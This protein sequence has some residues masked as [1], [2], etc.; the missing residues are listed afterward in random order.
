MPGV[1]GPRQ[2]RPSPPAIA[3][4]DVSGCQEIGRGGKNSAPSAWCFETRPEPVLGPRKARTR[5]ALLSM[6]EAIDSIKGIPRPEV[7]RAPRNG[8]K[9]R[10]SG[11]RPRPS[12]RRRRPRL[13]Q[14][15]HG[16]DPAAR[17]LDYSLPPAYGRPARHETLPCHCEAPSG[18]AAISTPQRLGGRDC[19]VAPLLAMTVQVGGRHSWL[20]FFLAS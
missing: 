15:T 6:R 12:R 20:C 10:P 4:S 3:V 9:G 7:P 19:F 8:P 11:G 14:E 2:G 5:G 16:I 18:A 13:P 17:Q 1:P